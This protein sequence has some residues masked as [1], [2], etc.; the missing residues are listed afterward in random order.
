VGGKVPVSS[1]QGYLD[2]AVTKADEIVHAIAV[3]VRKH[4]RADVLSGLVR[5]AYP[6]ARTGTLAPPRSAGR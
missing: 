4:A 1:R 6:V 2:T 5:S 3:K